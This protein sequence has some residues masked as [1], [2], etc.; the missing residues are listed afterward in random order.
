MRPETLAFWDEYARRHIVWTRFREIVRAIQG[1]QRVSDFEK[2]R[3]NVMSGFE[4]TIKWSGGEAR[5]SLPSKKFYRGLLAD[6]FGVK[7]SEIQQGVCLDGDEATAEWWTNYADAVQ[8]WAAALQF[9]ENATSKA[10]ATRLEARLVDEYELESSQQE[11]GEWM[12]REATLE[13]Y[14]SLGGVRFSGAH[15]SI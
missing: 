4:A 7:I 10:A 3:E 13:A 2:I 12:Y 6:A 8:E 9:V 14:L 5:I 11:D 15:H 1:M